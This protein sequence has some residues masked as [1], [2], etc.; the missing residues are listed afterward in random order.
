MPM[1]CIVSL[2]A[3]ACLLWP[4][5][6]HVHRERH[7]RNF[8][9]RVWQDCVV[10]FVPFAFWASFCRHGEKP[11]HTPQYSVCLWSEGVGLPTR[12]RQ[13]ADWPSDWL[14]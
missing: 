1:P 2:W 8:P 11:L 14:G 5:P 3:C 10:R 4:I 12:S 13:A 7:H 9:D 6:L